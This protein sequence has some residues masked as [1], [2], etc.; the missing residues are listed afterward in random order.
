MLITEYVEVTWQRR[1]IKHYKSKGYEYTGLNEILTV[2]VEDLSKGSHVL[3]DTICDYCNESVPPKSYKEFLTHREKNEMYKDCCYDCGKLKR[4]ESNMKVY[5]VDN[6]MKV[7]EFKENQRKT[8]QANYG[9][10][11]P[12]QNKEILEKVKRTNMERYGVD[13]Y[14]KTQECQDKMKKTNLERYGVE[15]YSMTD[16]WNVKVGNTVR[17]RYGVDSISQIPEVM[18][19]KI[20]TMYA[21]GTIATSSQQI[22]IHNLLDGVLNYPTERSTLDIAFPDEMIYVEY[23]GG[24]HNLPVK[25]GIMTQEEFDKKEKRRTFSLFDRGWKEIRLASDKDKLP[26]DLE[27]LRTVEKA[28]SFLIGERTKSIIVNWDEQSVLFSFK[29]LVSLE[30]FLDDDFT[31]NWEVA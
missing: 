24:G 6:P 7:D 28:R 10:D 12:L 15:H 27:I 22:Y 26:E 4:A 8:I 5:G 2:R 30:D 16:E 3:V 25:L 21:N 29:K 11:F 17:M 13:V 31:L 19:K 9:V 1:N 20:D 18:Q 23:D 14:A